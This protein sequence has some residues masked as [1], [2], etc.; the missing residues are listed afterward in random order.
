MVVTRNTK[1]LEKTWR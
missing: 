1:I